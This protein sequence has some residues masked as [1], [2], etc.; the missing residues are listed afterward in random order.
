[1]K[2]KF[3]SVSGP[4]SLCLLLVCHPR[5]GKIEGIYTHFLHGERSIA[6]DTLII[7][8][9]TGAKEA[10]Q[11]ENRTTYRQIIQ[12]SLQAKKHKLR[13]WT[14]YWDEKAGAFLPSPYYQPWRTVPGS[15]LLGQANYQKLP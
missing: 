10:Y 11:I 13:I 2:I 9:I 12:G 15:L 5:K 7:T 14:A 3:A 1:M 6:W 4:L 8:L